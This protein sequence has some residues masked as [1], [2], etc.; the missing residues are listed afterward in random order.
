MFE[1]FE[2]KKRTLTLP[3]E[4]SPVKPLQKIVKFY[5]FTF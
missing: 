3:T 2:L 5:K 4:E 1:Q